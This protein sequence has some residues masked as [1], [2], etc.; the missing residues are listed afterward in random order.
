MYCEDVQK[1]GTKHIVSGIKH[2]R[3]ASLASFTN[4]CKVTASVNSLTPVRAEK[5]TS[6][7]VNGIWYTRRNHKIKD[8]K[9]CSRRSE[10]GITRNWHQN[11]IPSSSGD[12]IPISILEMK[13]CKDN[14]SLMPKYPGSSAVIRSHNVIDWT[15]MDIPLGPKAVTQPSPRI[16]KLQ[17]A[18][19][20]QVLSALRLDRRT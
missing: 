5:C 8:G 10:K 12:I 15:Q 13:V 19:S 20:A 2:K 18:P 7:H 3:G 4:C 6:S 17:Q 14:D 16:Q 1:M 9:Y 11:K